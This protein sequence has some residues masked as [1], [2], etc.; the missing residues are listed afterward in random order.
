MLGRRCAAIPA[1]VIVAVLALTSGVA[2]AGG[3]DTSGFGLVSSDSSRDASGAPTIRSASPQGGGR[4]PEAP[5]HE[6]TPKESSRDG[7]SREGDSS[8]GDLHEGGSSDGD[9]REGDSPNGGSPNE[10]S[11]DEGT[12]AR[13]PSSGGGEAGLTATQLPQTLTRGPQALT[14]LPA[15]A[16]QA[17]PSSAPSA[18]STTT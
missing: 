2:A 10:G 13:V 12:G 18:F 8:D 11:S 14:Q 4:F 7:D 17:A 6:D 1:V 16:P 9:S 5:V 3:L 15:T